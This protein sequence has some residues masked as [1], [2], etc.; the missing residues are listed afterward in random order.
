M[1]SRALEWY[2]RV[3]RTEGISDEQLNH[4]EE[5]LMQADGIGHWVVFEAE[6]LTNYGWTAVQFYNAPFACVLQAN[7]ARTGEGFFGGQRGETRFGNNKPYSHI[8]V[9]V[10]VFLIVQ[11]PTDKPFEVFIKQGANTTTQTR[12]RLRR[13][14]ELVMDVSGNQQRNH[15][16]LEG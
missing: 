2:G 15:F 10:K 1:R 6:V 11:L 12:V 5:R 16:F 8:A 3:F 4:I 14:G 13:N 9:S 7:R